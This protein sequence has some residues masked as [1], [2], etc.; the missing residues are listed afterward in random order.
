[1]NNNPSGQDDYSFRDEGKNAESLMNSLNDIS[2]P[3]ILHVLIA[4]GYVTHEEIV[5]SERELQNHKEPQNWPGMK[6]TISA[7]SELDQNYVRTYSSRENK[8]VNFR[9]LRKI[10]GKHKWG[11]KIG[12]A[13]FGWKWQRKSP[14]TKINITRQQSNV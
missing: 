11:R 14:K 8:P 5:N 1:M 6:N 13:L 9:Q 3:A 12:S 2:L 4:K 7:T 10:L